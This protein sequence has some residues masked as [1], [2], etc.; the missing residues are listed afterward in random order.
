MTGKRIAYF[1]LF[2]VGLLLP[3]AGFAQN[4]KVY[5]TVYTVTGDPYPNVIVELSNA[6]TGLKRAALS[7]D[8]GNYNFTEVPPAEG[9]NISATINGKVIAQQTGL[10]VRV[11]DEKLL[12]PPLQEIAPAAAGTAPAEQK[13]KAKAA[14]ATVANDLATQFSTVITSEQLQSLPV[15]NR[16]FLAFGLLSPYTHDVEA[17]SPLAGATFSI[18]GNRPSSN[19]FLLDGA[20]NVASSS[21]QAIPFQVN[22]SVQEFRVTSSL[23]NA[24][25]GRNAGGVVNVVT[26]RAYTGWHGKMFGY[27]GSDKLNSDSPLS[28][29]S[30][31]GFAKSSAYAGSLVAGP[32]QR[33]FDPAQSVN[34][35]LVAPDYNTYVATAQANG[36]CTD[37]ISN[38]AGAA[39]NTCVANGLGRNTFFNP[40]AIMAGNDSHRQPF[41]SQQFGAS[42]GGG[43]R[44]DHMFVFASYEGTRIDNPTPIFERVPSE[45]DKSPPSAASVTCP[46]GTPNCFDTRSQKIAQGVLS[47]YPN[48]NVTAVPGVLEYYRGTAPNYTNVDNM[49]LRTD[50]KQSEQTDWTLRYSIQDLKQLHDDTLPSGGL[51]PGN[52]AVRTALNQNGILSYSHRFGA[53]ATNEARA[54]ASRFQVIE[55]PQDA[56]FDATTIGLPDSPMMTFLLSGLDPRYSGARQGTFGAYTGWY[57]SFWNQSAAPTSMVPSLDGL[58]PFARIGAPLGA[59]GVRRDSEVFGTDGLSIS[60]G[61]HTFKMGGEYRRLENL[62]STA[63]FARGLVV[64]SD[65]GEFTS[66]SESCNSGSCTAFTTPSFD[67]ALRQRA[68]YIGV[69][70][71]YAAAG[72][73]QDSWRVNNHLLLNYGVRYEFFSVPVEDNNQLWNFDPVSNGLYRAGDGAIVDPWGNSCA[74]TSRTD[75]LYPAQ[76]ATQPWRCA[77]T[78]AHGGQILPEQKKNFAPRF[79][80]VYSFDRTGK[81]V[82]RAGVGYF[83][84]QQPLS[85]MTQLLFNRPTP[86]NFAQ[87]QAIYGQN[88]STSI[89]GGA[90]CGLGNYSLFGV[91]PAGP[92][93]TPDK[94]SFQSAAVP[95]AIYSRDFDNSKTPYTRQVSA[96]FQQQ[97]TSHLIAEFGYM[98]TSGFHLPIVY[99]SGFSNEFFCTTTPGCDTMSFFPV[100]TMTNRASSEYKSGIV[101]LRAAGWNGL[102]FNLSYTYA[103]GYDS[104]SQGTYPLLISTLP[105]QVFGLQAFGLGN[106]SFLTFNSGSRLGGFGQNAQAAVQ[107]AQSAGSPNLSDLLVAGLTTTGAS[108]INV[109]RYDIPQDPTNFLHNEWGPSDFDTTHRVVFDYVWALPL[110]K[111]SRL[112]SNWQLSGIVIGQSGQPFTIFSGPAYGEVT[113]RA[114]VSGFTTTGNANGYI[115]GQISLPGAACLADATARSVYVTGAPLFGGVAGQPCIGSSG[116]NA[117]TG[118]A[119]V[120]SNIAIQKTFYVSGEETRQIIL[121]TEVFN[122]LNRANFYNPIS[123]VSPNGVIPN[124]QFGHILSAHEGR[125]VQLAIR[126]VW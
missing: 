21:N 4:A 74:P 8:G 79:G 56:R 111:D 6:S 30:N 68:S 41:S 92:G 64:S 71:S 38:L 101:Q 12:I 45:I 19:D 69:F 11:G 47:L 9:Y 48:A 75:F 49:L 81:S 42:I 85:T 5:G 32:A 36:Y 34:P 58:F 76:S 29:Y 22:D 23:A 59:P 67:Y 97:V 84:D 62:S 103:R 61:R 115:G 125:Q 35:P 120:T 65:I 107:A 25:F 14:A 83:Y 86:V 66:D 13:T 118:P 123:N 20:D 93:P 63:G 2:A 39:P 54:G 60:I 15:Y 51:Y 50:F 31:S 124:P 27:F 57:N 3:A 98:G 116:R 109:S 10:A 122:M 24:E 28:V 17:G 102:S 114:N 52:G 113:Q 18:A 40:G 100:Y 33:S 108:A 77:S 1:L 126:F 117:F 119:Y 46:G 78:A 53:K 37:S 121:R 106:P 112:L 89:C 73:G 72:Y 80:F 99:N 44:H 7:D 110:P 43:M 104:G 95:F 91:P 26:R 88:F 90:Q 70:H 55:T 82:L 94:Q 105:V 16:N 96:S 87:P